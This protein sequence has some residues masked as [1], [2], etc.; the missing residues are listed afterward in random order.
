MQVSNRWVNQDFLH[1]IAAM[2]LLFL[3]HILACTHDIT[4][5]YILQILMFNYQLIK[6]IS[7]IQNTSPKCDVLSLIKSMVDVNAELFTITY[8]YIMVCSTS[9]GYY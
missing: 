6:M 7:V 4:Q 3:I 1:K 5:G 2:P 8:Y 9:S